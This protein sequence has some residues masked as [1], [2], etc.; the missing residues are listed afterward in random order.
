M[1]LRRV[2]PVM[3][4]VALAAAASCSGGDSHTTAPDAGSGGSSGGSSGASGSAGLAGSAGSAG[5]AGSAGSAGLA[6]SA[7]SAGLGGSGGGAAGSAGTGG[8]AGDAGLAWWD[9]AAT[10]WKQVSW[11][12]LGCDI[13]YALDPPAA[14][15][16][17]D[18]KACTGGAAG[19]EEL[20]PSWPADVT[21]VHIAATATRTSSGRRM[22][23]VYFG[24]RSS[25]WVIRTVLYDEASHT[26]AAIRS[27]SLQCDVDGAWVSGDQTC[28]MINH[29]GNNTS[30]TLFA[31]GA[32]TAPVT[33]AQETA[34]IAADLPFGTFSG[35]ILAMV[36]MAPMINK[37]LDVPAGQ[38][39][40][41]VAPIQGGDTYDPYAVGSDVLVRAA[42]SPSDHAVA[43]LWKRPDTTLTLIDPPGSRSLA[44]V[45]SDGQSLVWIE[46]DTPY[47]AQ[48]NYPHGYLYA[49]PFAETASAVQPKMIRDLPSDVST[50]MPAVAGQGY[51]LIHRVVGRLDLFRISDGHHWTMTAPSGLEPVVA[52]ISVD[53]TYAIYGANTPGISQTK[54]IVR[55]RLDA[56][57]PGD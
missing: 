33:T 20:D 34:S 50:Y 2:L 36:T 40:N 22:A 28:L 24:Q 31:C 10:Q 14:A 13:Q 42:S 57:G 43:E 56:L 45:R 26:V 46:A 9:D 41:L 7:G 55:Q 11:A 54:V 52:P 16:P 39:H 6:G 38:F 17:L 23:A 19:C 49:S 3:I 1:T 15:P 47:D 12:P 29:V 21:F 30:S 32:G 53:A 5:L 48:G 8:Q 37:V 4:A 35:Q 44:D 51:Y 18:W 27:A 25:R